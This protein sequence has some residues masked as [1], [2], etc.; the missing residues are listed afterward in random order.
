MKVIKQIRECG[1]RWDEEVHE[2]PALS[3]L[4]GG[5]IFVF[6]GTLAYLKRDEAKIKIEALGGRVSK[7]VSG[8]TDFVI[9]GTNPGSKL[10][11]A[12][13]LGIEVLNEEK[14]IALLAGED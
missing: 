8:K 11:K 6:T 12:M 10:S 2:I 1:V 3:S 5:K 13:E 7:S 4:V 14:F 9:V